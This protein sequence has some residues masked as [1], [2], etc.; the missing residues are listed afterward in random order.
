MGAVKRRQM[1][2][3]AVNGD[4]SKAVDQRRRELAAVSPDCAL[5]SGTKRPPV[6]IRPPRPRSEAVSASWETA[7]PVPVRH[8]CAM[9]RQD[10]ALGRRAH[11]SITLPCVSG[12][13]W[14]YRCV[15]A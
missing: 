15:V 14:V 1:R 12:A 8:W 2:S 4:T 6:Q 9:T 11:E 5:S 7:F 10:A 3:D 13:R